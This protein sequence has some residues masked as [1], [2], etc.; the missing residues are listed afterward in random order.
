MGAIVSSAAAPIIE[1]QKMAKV[2]ELRQNKNMRDTQM[3]M[4]IAMTKDR[5][6]WMIGAVGALGTI[7]GLRKIAR[8][9][10]A[11][12]IPAI[13][14]IIVSAVILYQA[15]LVWGDKMNRI[16]DDAEHIKQDPRFWFNARMKL[17]PAMRDPYRKA[18]DQLN[19]DLEAAG[20]PRAQEWAE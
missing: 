2:M 9:T 15:D 8:V 18:M 17:P 10:P 5:V 13:P 6:Y 4:N 1:Q 3:A 11:M 19:K 7:G 20:E 16:H 12:P 14:G